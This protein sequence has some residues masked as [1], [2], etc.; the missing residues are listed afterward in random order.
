[1]TALQGSDDAGQRA[2]IGCPTNPPVLST[3]PVASSA[4]V[5][6]STAVFPEVLWTSTKSYLLSTLR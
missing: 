2:G 4:Q 5:H 3:G 6:P 1:M